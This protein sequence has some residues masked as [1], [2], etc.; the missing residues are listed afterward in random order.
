MDLR[1]ALMVSAVIFS[2]LL[3]GRADLIEMKSG[4]KIEGDVLK[5]TADALLV[6][7]G[8]D[9]LRIPVDKIRSRTKPDHKE[10]P[11]PG[12]RRIRTKSRRTPSIP[13]PSC[14]WEA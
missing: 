9:I 12:R 11:I 8:F 3:V 4:H 7:V 2:G 13:P 5:E 6:D 1:F 14:R 10:N